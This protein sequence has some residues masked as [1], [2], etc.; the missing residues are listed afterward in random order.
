[1]QATEG[2]QIIRVPNLGVLCTCYAEEGA[3]L[4]PVEP[5]RIELKP[6][7]DAFKLEFVFEMDWPGPTRVHIKDVVFHVVTGLR[8]KALKTAPLGPGDTLTVTYALSVV[9]WGD[10][11]D[12]E[13][14][15]KSW[16]KKLTSARWP[17][18]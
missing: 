4:G 13:V 8:H 5:I 12:G 9:S 18:Q 1:M 10:D 7:L 2:Y 14:F 11:D 3:V 16:L 6:Y 17:G 15:Q